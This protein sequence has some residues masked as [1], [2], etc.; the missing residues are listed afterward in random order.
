MSHTESGDLRIDMGEQQRVSTILRVLYFAVHVILSALMILLIW[1]GF[2]MSHY[3]DGSSTTPGALLCGVL[4]L[5]VWVIMAAPLLL[6]VGT[7]WVSRWWVV[8]HGLLGAAS[9]VVIVY[10]AIFEPT[11]SVDV[12]N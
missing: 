5:L 4:S 8:P 12:G 2:V 3:R 6:A 11:G 10:A 1:A 7:K 9:L